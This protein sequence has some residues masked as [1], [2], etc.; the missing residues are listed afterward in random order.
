[1]DVLHRPIITEKVTFLG[2]RHTD[3]QYAFLVDMDA[4]KIQIKLAIEAKYAVQVASVRTVIKPALR[5][6]R[7]TKTGI[8]KGKTTP[9]KKAYITLVPG[10]EIDLYSNL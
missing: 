8:L 9:T 4:N 10:Q 6:Q 7:Y 3:K 2:E 1:M 5:R